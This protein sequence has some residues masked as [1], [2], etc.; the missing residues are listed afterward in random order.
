MSPFRDRLE[1]GVG[2]AISWLSFWAF[3]PFRSPYEIIFYSV[4]ITIFLASESV[5]LVFSFTPSPLSCDCVGTSIAQSGSGK[6]QAG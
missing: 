1:F 6:C 3:P 5:Q 2:E 4:A